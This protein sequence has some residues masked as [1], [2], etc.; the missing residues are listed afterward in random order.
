MASEEPRDPTVV[1][2]VRRDLAAIAKLDGPLA[3][4]SLAAS[5]LALAREIDGDNSATSK[6]MCSKSLNDT[7]ATLRAL[8]PE[9]KKDDTVDEI[10]DKRAERLARK[11][12]A[13]G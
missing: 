5:A 9:K 2:A 11:A 12:A 10:G 8:A 3:K 13:T 6:A 1:E 7:L 4:G